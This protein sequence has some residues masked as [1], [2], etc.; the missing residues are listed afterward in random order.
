[1]APRPR[2]TQVPKLLAAMVAGSDVALA[3]FRP[4]SRPIVFANAAFSEFTGCRE[5]PALGRDFFDCL[6]GSRR[7]PGARCRA[8]P[9]GRPRATGRRTALLDETLECKHE[10][11]T[12]AFRRIVR[13]IERTVDRKGPPL[14]LPEREI[15]GWWTSLE[16]PAAQVIALYADHATAEQFHSELKTDLDI[17][18]LP[19]GKFATNALLLAL[20]GLAY[21]RSRPGKWCMKPIASS[22]GDLTYA[23]SGSAGAL[24]AGC[25]RASPR[26]A[27]VRIA[28][29]PKKVEGLGGRRSFTGKTRLS[30]HGGNP[31]PGP[32][33]RS[34]RR[35]PIKHKNQGRPVVQ[36]RR[37]TRPERAFFRIVG[38]D[39]PA[40]RAG[41]WL[42]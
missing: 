18:R 8:A 31:Y 16:L 5:D 24:V 14:L 25:R 38:V 13:L 17:E 1:M 10:G 22:S 42:R 41:G 33:M 34:T 35:M 32:P 39:S 9:P 11:R 36:P 3:A 21:N 23:A 4:A 15:E 20:A 28:R 40:R 2:E 7:S 37:P 12:Y 27:V 19:S 26:P 29:A 6:G 30:W